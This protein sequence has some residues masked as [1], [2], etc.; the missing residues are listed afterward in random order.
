MRRNLKPEI[1]GARTSCGSLIFQVV[2]ASVIPGVGRLALNDHNHFGT[3]FG[4]NLELRGIGY[5]GNT[6]CIG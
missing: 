3:F 2:G 1:I 5:D 4:V 6:V